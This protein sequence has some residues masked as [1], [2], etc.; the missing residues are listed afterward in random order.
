[1]LA[2]A[3]TRGADDAV[4]GRLPSGRIEFHIESGPRTLVEK[5][6]RSHGD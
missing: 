6:A 1:M 4:A 5:T 2:A 3:R